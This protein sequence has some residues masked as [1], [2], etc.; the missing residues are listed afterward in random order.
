MYKERYDEKLGEYSLITSF[1]DTDKGSIE[2]IYDEGFRGQDAL[3]RAS[4]FLTS[5]LGMSGLILRSVISIRE[6]S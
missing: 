3:K 6:K 2:M 4:D 1:V 5:N